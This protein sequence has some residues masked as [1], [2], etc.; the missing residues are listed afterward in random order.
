MINWWGL[1]HN[2]LWVVGLVVNLG[3]LSVASYEAHGEQVRL[4]Q[5]LKEP[6]FQLPFSI[7][8]A[9]FCL[10]LVFSGQSWWEH[11]IWDL[12]AAVF[13]GQ[14]IWLWRRGRASRTASGGP[15]TSS[16]RATASRSRKTK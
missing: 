12:L 9:L 6:S 10:G 15:H 5:K 2:S 7:G 8:M 13:A 11:V 16:E 14:T 3:T 1:F 4:R